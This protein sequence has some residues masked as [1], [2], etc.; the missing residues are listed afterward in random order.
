MQESDAA[1]AHG[2]IAAYGFWVSLGKQKVFEDSLL[3]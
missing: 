3:S 2:A 1:V